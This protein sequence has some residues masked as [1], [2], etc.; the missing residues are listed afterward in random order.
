M[1]GRAPQRF[2][3]LAVEFHLGC[4]MRGPRGDLIGRRNPVTLEVE[5]YEAIGRFAPAGIDLA[6]E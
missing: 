6:P 4:V 1:D 5:Q 3:R 2:G